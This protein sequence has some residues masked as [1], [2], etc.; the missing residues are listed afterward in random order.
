MDGFVT[1]Q[2]PSKNSL[3]DKPVLKNI[4]A[5]AG[6]VHHSSLYVS[7]IIFIWIAH[8]PRWFFVALFVAR[9]TMSR[10]SILLVPTGADGC[11]GSA[12]WTF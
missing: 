8:P 3:H 9:Q 2:E 10:L 4:S 12:N 7:V 1:K 6:V 5:S 11:F